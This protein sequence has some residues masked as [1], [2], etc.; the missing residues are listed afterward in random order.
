M[1]QKTTNAAR[2]IITPSVARE[3]VLAVM[4]KRGGKPIDAVRLAAVV[5]PCQA[6]GALGALFG[7][8]RVAVP[9]AAKENA[10][11]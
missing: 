4:A 11:R 10:T 2:S 1:A 7:A 8:F 6:N 9:R 3:A 5:N